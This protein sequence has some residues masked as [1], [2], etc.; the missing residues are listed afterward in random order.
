MKF[1]IWR[2][3]WRSVK[4][5]YVC[6]S[7]CPLF[8]V[9]ARHIGNSS[10][11]NT[12]PMPSPPFFSFILCM[13]MGVESEYYCILKYGHTFLVVRISKHS[14]HE[15]VYS[16]IWIPDSRPYMYVF[17]LMHWSTYGMALFQCQLIRW[18]A[19]D[20]A[21][22][23]F[24]FQEC[25]QSLLKLLSWSWKALKVGLCE[26]SHSPGST[27]RALLLDL[28]RLLY[29]CVASLHLLRIYINEVYP[30]GRKLSLL[31]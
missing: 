31:Y 22:P 7:F 3:W 6:Q 8:G 23:H 28:R 27:S 2:L 4:S 26:V 10:D 5:I 12:N 1:R 30:A 24:C 21:L 16:H 29:V 19:L 11:S 14:V 13:P 17:F 25:F 20:W 18:L 15:E 9:L